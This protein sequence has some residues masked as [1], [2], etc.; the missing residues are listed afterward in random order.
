MTQYRI[1]GL[2][3]YAMFSL[4]D[5]EGGKVSFFIHLL[6]SAGKIRECNSTF[7][8]SSDKRFL[9]NVLIEKKK[10]RA[11]NMINVKISL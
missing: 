3:Y 4:Y 11:K 5:G 10:T 2:V 9:L 7:F 8:N 1:K 6:P